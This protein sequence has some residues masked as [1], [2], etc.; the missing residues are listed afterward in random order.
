MLRE[1]HIEFN[2]GDVDGMWLQTASEA[3]AIVRIFG[4]YTMVSRDVEYR[5]GAQEAQGRSVVQHD[6]QQ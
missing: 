3:S 6:V 5:I 1:A 2:Y 4:P